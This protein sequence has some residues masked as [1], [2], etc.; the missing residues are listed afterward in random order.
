MGFCAEASVQPGG[1]CTGSLTASLY[2]SESYLNNLMLRTQFACRSTPSAVVPA[3][4]N[5]LSQGNSD[6]VGESPSR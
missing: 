2:S 1:R 5:P 3:A 4:A 6:A